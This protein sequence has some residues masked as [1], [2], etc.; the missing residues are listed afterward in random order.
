MNAL[1]LAIAVL[2]V[3]PQLIQAGRDVSELINHTSSV[4]KK[5]QEEKR[6]PTNEEWIFLDNIATELRKQLDS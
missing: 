4:I 5:A 6:D 3:L 2:D 1:S